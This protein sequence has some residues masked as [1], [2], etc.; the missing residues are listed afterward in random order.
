MQY[1]FIPAALSRISLNCQRYWMVLIHKFIVAL[2]LMITI[3]S[4][5]AQGI[6]DTKLEKCNTILN[7]IANDNFVRDQMFG[8]LV[9]SKLHAI[10]QQNSQY[11]ASYLATSDY[12][13]DGKYGRVTQRWLAHFCHEFA[14]PT[15]LSNQQ[16][17]EQLLVSLITI[18]DMTQT[19]SDWRVTIYTP[20]F[21]NWASAQNIACEQEL[22][23]YG[24][25]SEIHVLL[26]K[27]YLQQYVTQVSE[28]APIMPFFYQITS[29]DLAYFT[30]LNETLSELQ[31]LIGQTFESKS[32][33]NNQLYPLL[34]VLIPQ[35]L[36]YLDELIEV[37]DDTD[38][39]TDESAFKATDGNDEALNNETGKEEGIAAT[40]PVLSYKITPQKLHNLYRQLSID[41][42]T[43]DQLTQLATVQ[44]I[45]FTQ[46]Y[47]LEVALT[48]QGM[49]ELSPLAKALILSRAKKMGMI[50]NKTAL[51]Y[52]WQAIENCG[53]AAYIANAQD[54]SK[55]YYAF[56]PSWMPDNQRV[57]FSKLTRVGY[58]SASVIEDSY[59][60]N[61][62]VPP[63]NWRNQ[64]PYSNFVHLAHQHKVKVD[65]VVSNLR[66]TLKG[67]SPNEEFN[68]PL[69]NDIHKQVTAP[70]NDY[71]LEH[72]KPLLS[73][74]TSPS[75]TMA[76]GV[77][78]NFE[79]TNN[80]KTQQDEFKSFIKLL[81]ERLNQ[82]SKQSLLK[83][84]PL[85]N[86]LSQA[87]T[88]TLS[89]EITAALSSG[90]S[91]NTA[92]FND[93]YYLNMMVPAKQVLANEGFYTLENLIAIAPHINVFIM[94]FE[95]QTM[96][97]T[98]NIAA[99]D[100]DATSEND[101]LALMKA[102]RE[103]MTDKKYSNEIEL[104]YNKMVP[105]LA[106]KMN[107]SVD[108]SAQYIEQYTR[109]NYLG[110]AY[111]T[112]P[113]NNSDDVLN[114]DVIMT[115]LKKLEFNK[116]LDNT[117]SWVCDYLCP[118][119]WLYRAALFTLFIA[120]LFYVMLSVWFYQLRIILKTWYFIAYN[121][122]VVVFLMMVFSCDPFWKEYR[123]F[124]LVLFALFT[125]GLGFIRR[126]MREKVGE[127]P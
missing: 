9:Q 35:P 102:L 122:G 27:Y 107:E 113:T 19:Y 52:Q 61:R 30:M 18:A 26:D 4:T 23:C 7:N 64:Q 21:N 40:S 20:P 56:A 51:P 101:T 75:R 87:V 54:V 12:L 89:P 57:D 80:N 126:L 10:Y 13:K 41:S 43:K 65:L 104:L 84:P 24:S 42:L 91:L 111:W 31:A 29:D 14:L 81:K 86:D 3:T 94:V 90:S 58:F 71:L 60:V 112:L 118:Q 109:W 6:T 79:L 95:P 53:C 100:D 11:Q 28:R 114:Q 55:L 63:L 108:K 62:L 120:T 82:S 72:V 32:A 25:P 127:L 15:T 50:K 88:K 85:S 70:L 68:E 48:M 110:E 37:S 67:I 117:A 73:F 1:F 44:D 38:E 76:D 33:I 105:L 46:A 39:K 106:T 77:T 47:L 2:V 36:N 115:E 116:A 5:Q 103:K 125:I 34:K 119:R 98:D 78:L 96:S 124:M 8:Q 83:L 17:V 66:E 121:A 69:V 93:Q 74:G 92:S 59:G 16:F 45:V 99:T 123:G 97:I 49:A 22:S